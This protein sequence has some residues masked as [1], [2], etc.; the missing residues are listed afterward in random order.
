MYYAESDVFRLPDESLAKTQANGD[1]IWVHHPST[2][3]EVAQSEELDFWIFGSAY[4]YFSLSLVGLK[5]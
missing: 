3:A 1:V 4:M 2:V 5:L